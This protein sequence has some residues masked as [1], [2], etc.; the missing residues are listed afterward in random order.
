MSWTNDWQIINCPIGANLQQFTRNTNRAESN[1]RGW[2]VHKVYIYSLQFILI[3]EGWLVFLKVWLKKILCSNISICVLILINIS[4]FSTFSANLQL[5]A[6][7]RIEG[8]WSCQQIKMFIYCFNKT[9]EEIKAKLGLHQVMLI[10][11]IH[12]TPCELVF[13]RWCFSFRSL[14][15]H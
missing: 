5:Q 15:H 8:S 11:C 14:Y 12:H 1:A 10:S 3:P 7:R 2:L 13:Q 6:R 9:L 4:Y